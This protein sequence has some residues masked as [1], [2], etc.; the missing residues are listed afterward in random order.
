MVDHFWIMAQTCSVIA[1]S[2]SSGKGKRPKLKDFLPIMRKQN[3][4]DDEMAQEL[5]S[6]LGG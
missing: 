6:A 3:Q 2:M 5:S 4:T 1:N